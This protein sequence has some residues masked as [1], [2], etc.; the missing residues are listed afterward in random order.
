MENLK[1]VLDHAN[2]SFDNVVMAR[3]FLTDFRDFQSVNDVFLSYFKEDRRPGRTTI[4]AIALAGQGDVEV[5]FIVYCG[6]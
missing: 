4:G 5:D 6:N 2:A 3:L 1:I